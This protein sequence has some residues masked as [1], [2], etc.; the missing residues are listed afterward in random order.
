MSKFTKITVLFGVVL[1]GGIACTPK[2]SPDELLTRAE[3]AI[4]TGELA[5]AEIDLKAV[6]RDA[7]DDARGRAL[8]GQI[9]MRRLEA[10]AAVEQFERS[11]ASQESVDTRLF[12]AKALVQAS[13]SAELVS[14]WQAGT[15]VSVESESQFQAALAQ[16]FLAQA[17]PDEARAA[18]ERALAAS[19]GEEDYVAF[20][21]A[22]IALQLDGDQNAAKALLEGIVDR[23]PTHARAW[24]LLGLLAS[25]SKDFDAA[26]KFYEKAA[27]ANPYRV[28]DRIQLVETQVRLGKADIAS[29]NL[30]KL[31]GQLRNYPA[32][33]FL[34]GQLMFDEGNYEGAI[35]LFN[36]ILSVTPDNPGTLLLAANA[37]ARVNKLPIAR[38]HF[39]RFLQLQPG[40][41]Q[42]TLQL[43]QTNALMGQPRKTEE[44]A[45]ALLENEKDN[46][47]ALGLLASALAAQ[48]LH[49]ESAQIF[50]RLKELQPDST[51]NLVALGSQQV[52]A[53]DVDA[54]LMQLQGAVEKDPGSALARERLIEAR[55]VARDL[56][57]AADSAARYVES[58]PDSARAAVYLGRVKLQQNDMD[59]AR[60]MFDRALQLDPSNVPARGGLAAVAVLGKDLEGAKAQFEEALKSNPGDLQS[61]LNLA[62]ILEQLGELQGMEDVLY[63]AMDANPTATTPRIAIARKAL[64]DGKPAVA[65]EVLSPED[66]VQ[67]KDFRVIQMLAAA[68]ITADQK[69]LALASARQLLELRPDD[70]AALALGA[71]AHLLSRELAEAQVLLEQALDANPQNVPLRKVLI[72]V[73]VMQNEFEKAVDELDQLPLESQN[74]PAVYRLRGRNALIQSDVGAAVDWLSQAYASA[75]DRENL[76]LLSTAR[77]LDGERDDVLNV[78]DGWVQTH[79]KDLGVRS[80]LAARLIEAGKESGAIAQYRVLV[81][82]NPDDVI[83]LN[84][85]AWLLREDETDLALEY[86]QRAETLAPDSASVA[87]TYA[88]IELERGDFDHALTLNQRAL[89]LT[90]DANEIVL[91]RARILAKAGRTTEAKRLLGEVLDAASG[92]SDGDLGDAARTLLDTLSN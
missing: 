63:A 29:S 16:G 24:S 15:F 40:N 35:N 70:P 78:L 49:A 64:T 22:L 37:N 81:D 43:A 39:E 65:I 23:T 50:L 58:S 57:G 8:Y 19:T 66:I 92:G 11:L 88:M 79:P 10:A 86:I 60:D 52:I 42:A 34:R 77:W 6:L 80:V 74:D 73:F 7:P 83:A 9:N 32:L 51:S 55:L 71:R 1:L 48:G 20:T 69:E 68:Y 67:Q 46:Q 56:D 4:K 45:R 89:E 62:V 13:E 33:T 18:L 44:L 61:S 41:V 47:T 5:A 30:T 82:Q 85:V 38:R 76:L 28:G 90:P 26:E 27:A 87:D 17:Q 84:N 25:Q 54:G 2:L 53:G 75:P 12:F 31:E 36:Q 21:E 72:D 91:N 14:E 3:T 59:A